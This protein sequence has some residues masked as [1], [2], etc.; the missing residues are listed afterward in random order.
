M[1]Q[2]HHDSSDDECMTD[3]AFKQA[4]KVIVND[5]IYSLDDSH[6]EGIYENIIDHEY[7]NL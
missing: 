1:N 6:I 7:K 3:Q 2:A 4:T 5:L